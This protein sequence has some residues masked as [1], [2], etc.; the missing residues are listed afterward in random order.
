MRNCQE[1]T[2]H[3]TSFQVD[4]K[5]VGYTCMNTL[6]YIRCMNTPMLVHGL[7]FSSI[8]LYCTVWRHCNTSSD[9]G[10]STLYLLTREPQPA[11]LIVCA[12]E[13]ASVRVCECASVRVRECASVRV[14]ECA[15]ACACACVSVSV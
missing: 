8:Q 14:C 3:I 9:N 11:C 5:P 4:N 2:T 13:R 12:S 1:T 7:S 6:Y 10:V 15:S